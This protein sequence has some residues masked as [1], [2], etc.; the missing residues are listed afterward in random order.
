MRNEILL[1]NNW[2]F[3]RGDIEAHRP[4]T[5]APVYSQSKTERKLAGPAAYNYLDNPDP[6]GAVGELKS[7]GWVEVTIPHDYVVQQDLQENENNALGY[8]KYENAWYRKHFTLPEGSVNK[9]ITLRFDG[10][11]GKSTVYLNG[12]LMYHNFSNYNTFEIDIS[13][14]VYYDKENIIAVYTVPDEWEGWWYQGGGI[15]RNVHLTITDPVAIDLWG[16]YA[17]YKKIG[18]NS[19]KINFETTVVNDEYEDV[20]ISLKSFVLDKDG[21]C[22]ATAEGSGSIIQREK[23]TI[24]YGCVV[25]NPLLWDCE[26]PNLYTIKTLLFKDGEEIDYNFTRIGFRTVE[27]IANK[28]MFING[29]KE[30]I[31]GLCAHQDFGITGLAVPE[32]VAK[33]KVSLYKKMGANGY[34]TSHYQQTEAYMDAFDEMGFLVLDE[35]RWFETSKESFEQIESLVKRDRNR[36]SV[37]FW[38]TS[39]EEYYHVTDVG[40]R[41]HRAIAA[42][43]RKFDKVRPITA[44]V[45]RTPD[46]CTIYDYCEVV[47]INYNTSIYDTVHEQYPDKLIFASECAACPSVRDWHYPTNDFGRARDKDFDISDFFLGRESTWKH[48]MARPYVFGQYIWDAVEHR[49]EALWPMICSKS[50]LIDLFLY[51]K[52]A[53]YLMKAYWAKEPVAHIVPHWNFK[54]LEGQ[55]ILVTVYTNC[56][57]LELF[58]N[59][60]SIGRKQIEKYGHGEWNVPYEAGELSV[61]G[62]IDGKEVCEHKRITTGK[63]VSIRLTLDNEFEANGRDLALFTCECL[64]EQGRVVPDAA[65]FVKFTVNSPAVIVGTGSDNCDHNNVILPERKM[66]MGKIRIA[67]RPA[68]DQEKVELT[69]MSENCGLARITV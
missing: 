60:K 25:E 19:W 29:K 68:K 52:G 62:Y 11:A 4:V 21:N 56:E 22:V 6:G 48:L 10:I 36:P 47:G 53:F 24:E 46:K 20:N 5:K 15:Y 45:D 32:N 67:V 57:E 44:A 50:G 69:A 16:V 18:E 63:P 7:E 38:S 61:K 31:K 23:A 37:I 59:G 40:R 54:G 49:G 43:I 3:H 33:Y 39:N 42:H 12:C 30:F 14:N 58:L 8:L 34:R 64:D 66:Y 1:N 65:E 26:S 17:P 51:E 35:A 2:L 13:N 27:F 55:N 9:R 41:L 28:G